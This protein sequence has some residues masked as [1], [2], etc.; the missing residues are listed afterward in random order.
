MEP[1]GIALFSLPLDLLLLALPG[2]ASAGEDVPS[3][4]GTRCCKV[5]WYPRE[6]LPFSEEKRREK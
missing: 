4:A 2:W 1:G 5:E 6:G 3:P